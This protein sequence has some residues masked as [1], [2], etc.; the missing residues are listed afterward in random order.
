MFTSFF[1]S[2]LNTI[3]SIRWYVAFL[4]I[5]YWFN[6]LFAVTPA[7]PKVGALM[8]SP[9]ISGRT[10]Q[11]PFPIAE[12]TKVEGE[13]PKV[14]EKKQLLALAC[15]GDVKC[16]C[17]NN[18]IFTHDSSWATAGVG[19][20]ANNPGNMRIPKTWKPSV[21]FTVYHANGNGKFAKFSSLEDGIKAN[22]E[23]YHRFYKDLPASQLVS[24]WT[25]DDGDKN[26]HKAVSNC[27]IL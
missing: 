8:F 21:A 1:I 4:V 16:T 6:I 20:N 25:D 14:I 7:I 9:D 13:L 15:S 10:I 18:A 24:I 11:I 5:V 22:V 3:Y 12:S 17:I 23:L 19:K 26:Y 2:I 27:Y